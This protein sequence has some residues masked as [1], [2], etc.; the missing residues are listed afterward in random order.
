MS[1][2]Y[3]VYFHLVNGIVTTCSEQE[4]EEREAKLDPIIIE[5]RIGEHSVITRLE[6]WQVLHSGVGKR[7]TPFHISVDGPA[8]AFVVEQS[9]LPHRV[10]YDHVATLE[11]AK[12]IHF[13]LVRLL[14]HQEQAEPKSSMARRAVHNTYWDDGDD[15]EPGPSGTRDCQVIPDRLRSK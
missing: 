15:S 11:E 9:S 7:S 12:L 1:H 8:G 2:Q 13:A 4:W 10:V 5:S 14:A 3:D 6:S